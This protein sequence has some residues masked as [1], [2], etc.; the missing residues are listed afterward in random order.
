[1]NHSHRYYTSYSPLPDDAP[2]NYGPDGDDVGF[3]EAPMRE[4]HALGSDHQW[5]Q[6]VD[7][8]KTYALEQFKLE[9]NK[10]ETDHRNNP[11]QKTGHTPGK[12][13]RSSRS[14]KR[15]FACPFYIRSPADHIACFTRASFRRIKDVKQHVWNAHRLPPYCPI[16]GRIFPTMAICDEHIRSR[17][18][19]LRELPTPEGITVQQAQ[20]LAYP[21]DPRMHEELQWLSIWAIVFPGEHLPNATYPSCPMESTVC[22]FRDYWEDNG[23]KIVSGFLKERGFHNYDLPDEEGNLASLYTMVLHQVIDY[24]VDSFAQQDSGATMEGINRS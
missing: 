3:F 20:R 8:I 19:D 21:S 1:M 18:C 10:S 14:P 9:I 22:S 17:A 7:E 15:Q 24:L 13:R 4:P 11:G 16:C 5:A 23:R 12:G 2:D 6:T